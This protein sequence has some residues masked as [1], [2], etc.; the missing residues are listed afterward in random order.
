MFLW[1][2]Q[3]FRRRF[4][5]PDCDVGAAAVRVFESH[6]KSLLH[7]TASHTERSDLFDEIRLRERTKTLAAAAAIPLHLERGLSSGLWLFLV[8]HLRQEM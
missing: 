6:F 7:Q 5:Q 8:Q 1:V 2:V 4:P 3:Q